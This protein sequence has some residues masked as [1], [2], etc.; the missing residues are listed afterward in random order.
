MVTLLQKILLV[1]TPHPVRL[2]AT[3]ERRI[4]TALHRWTE[5][6]RY[7]MM[8]TSYDDIASQLNVTKRAFNTYFT[9]HLKEDF[10]TWRTRL[11]IEDAKTLLLHRPDLS[12][13]K[14]GATVGFSDRSNF[15]HQFLRYVGCTPTRWREMHGK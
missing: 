11:R 12:C 7:R 10:R 14:V 5:A 4:K 13:S 15:T 3:E 2:S 1:N 9:V 6:R 8:G